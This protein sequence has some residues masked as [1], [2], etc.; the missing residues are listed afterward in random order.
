M[1][2]SFQTNPFNQSTKLLAINYT[3][4]YEQLLERIENNCISDREYE[5]LYENKLRAGLVSFFYWDE[6]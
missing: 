5:E 3:E 6:K 2:T 1:K 4:I